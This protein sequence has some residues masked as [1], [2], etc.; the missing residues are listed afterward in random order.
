MIRIEGLKIHAGDFSLKIKELTAG[1]SEYFVILGPTGSGKTVFLEAAAGLRRPSAGDLWF[2]GRLVTHE[3]PERRGAGLVYQD[4]ALFPHLTVADNIGFGL[5]TMREGRDRRL[6]GRTERRAQIQSRIREVAALLGIEDLL[7]RYPEGLSGGEQQRVA[8]ARALAI[9]PRVLLLDE[10]LSALDTQTRR[11]LRLELKRLQRALG[12]TVMHVTHDLEEALA[13]GDRLAVMI[14]G[15]LRQVGPPQEVIRFPADIEVARLFGLTNVFRVEI[16]ERGLFTVR[17]ED[18]PEILVDESEDAP[19][20]NCLDKPLGSRW[21]VI[22]PEELAILPFLEDT[23]DRSPRLYPDGLSSWPEPAGY[24]LEQPSSPGTLLQGTVATI[25]LQSVCAS[26][27]IEVPPNFT[28][29]VLRPQVAKL[30]LTPG[31][32][33]ALWI[34]ASA[35]RLC[36]SGP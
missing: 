16:A 24:H 26:I 31:T 27:E 1:E 15:E 4:Y 13:L 29:H 8:L 12:T 20:G 25:Q 32:F 19:R 7:G 14:D 30:R 17:L 34:P 9:E 35:V 22:R 36:P 6:Q 23:L 2:G 10:P 33:V 28:V 21:A 11:E 5:R 18:G 3:P